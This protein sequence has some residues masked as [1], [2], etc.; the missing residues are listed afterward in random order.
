[1]LDAPL[2]HKV[3]HPTKFFLLHKRTD[4]LNLLYRPVSIRTAVSGCPSKPSQENVSYPIRHSQRSTPPNMLSFSITKSSAE[5]TTSSRIPA[6]IRRTLYTFL[7]APIQSGL[8]LRLNVVP[9]SNWRQW[10]SWR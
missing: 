7:K 1:M 10:W 4:D 6:G 8:K 3:D 2:N 5:T 9:L